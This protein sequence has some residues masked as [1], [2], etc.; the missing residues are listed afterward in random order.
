VGDGRFFLSPNNRWEWCCLPPREC[1]K[2]LLVLPVRNHGMP[3][4]QDVMEEFSSVSKDE[5]WLDRI[6]DS[7]NDPG[8]FISSKDG[9]PSL[10]STIGAEQLFSIVKLS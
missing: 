7:I 8:D 3:I 9:T 5:T 10:L 6:D 4:L 1:S 2:L